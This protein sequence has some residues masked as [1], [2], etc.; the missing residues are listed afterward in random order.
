MNVKVHK[1]YEQ[2]DRENVKI[3]NKFKMRNSMDDMYRCV[4][5]G[6]RASIDNSVSD[7]GHRLMHTWC[8]KMTFGTD[9]KDAFKWMEEQD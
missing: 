4:I 5:C 8:M 7:L 1:D 6:E 2:I 3:F 9:I